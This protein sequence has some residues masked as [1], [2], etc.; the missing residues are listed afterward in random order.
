MAGERKL[1]NQEAAAFLGVRPNTLA[2]WRCKHMGPRYSKLGRRVLYDIA[3][4]EE[5]FASRS[6]QTLES[7]PRS[8]KDG[9]NK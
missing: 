7:S 1:N 8:P 4:L 6:V 2:V 9:S 3:D 5:F